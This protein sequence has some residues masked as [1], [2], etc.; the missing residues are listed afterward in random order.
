MSSTSFRRPIG[1]SIAAALAFTVGGLTAPAANAASVTSAAF[2]GGA[3]TFTAANGT[4]Y[5][6]QGA[7]LTLT[8]NTDSSTQCVDVVDGAGATIA[9]Q[10]DKNDK[11]TWTF[12]GATYP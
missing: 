10:S 11:G 1:L 8:I 9:S 7:A 3:G 2:S 4:V 6:K 5:A 12:S